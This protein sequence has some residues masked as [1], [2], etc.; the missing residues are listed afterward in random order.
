MLGNL[1]SIGKYLVFG[2]LS[3]SCRY[4]CISTCRSVQEC[5]GVCGSVRECAGVCGSVRIC[6]GTCG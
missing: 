6:V 4:L 1:L 3:F 2:L 5:E